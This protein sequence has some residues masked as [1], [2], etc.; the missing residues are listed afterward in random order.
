MVM[1]NRELTI[2]QKMLAAPL[3]GVLL[4]SAYV[5]YIYG[6]H[7]ESSATISEI[8]DS[9]LPLLEISNENFLLFGTIA[10]S[11][12]DAVLAG[13][14]EWVI[15]TLEDKKQIE[16]NLSRMET[17]PPFVK[18]E[19]LR[20][21]RTIFNH[22]YENAFA[23]SMAMMEKKSMA[24][25]LN[26]L[27]ENLERYHSQTSDGFVTLKIDLETRFSQQIDET[28]HRLR[29]LVLIGVGLGVVL[30]LL[31]L[32]VTFRMSLSTRKSLSEVN[33]ALKSIAQ[34]NPDFSAR[35]NRQS[36]DELGEMVNWFNLLAEK[37]EKDYKKIELLSITDKLTQLYNRAKIDD[38]F[39]L[40]IHRSERYQ[41]P[42]SVILLDI[43]LFKSVNDTYGHQVGDKVL[44]ELAEILSSNIRESDHVGRWGGEE[45]III[46][47][48][49]TLEQARHQAEK[50]RLAIADFTFSTVGHKT[51]SFG[52]S[53]FHQGDDGEGLTKRADECLY[54]AKEKGRNVVVQETEL[55]TKDLAQ[56][57]LK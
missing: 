25:D 2:F 42:M 35:L 36:D 17:H 4:Y 41:L 37:L 20:H 13:E 45:F 28:N 49:S 29:R 54:I 46:S 51:A 53:T 32:G 57:H 38:L 18:T 21:L 52:I 1:R 48:N 39:Q 47:S 34:D 19:N 31:I 6:E 3:V 43:A 33:T 7:T 12:K 24:Q 30:V 8:R 15:N 11:L 22:Y 27:I 50:L 23:L 16:Q 26:Q 5:F 40:E 14:K 44:I 55:K 9:Y 10:G 56:E